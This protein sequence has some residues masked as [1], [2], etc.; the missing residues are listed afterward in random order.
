MEQILRVYKK[1]LYCAVIDFLAKVWCLAE[2]KNIKKNRDR[3]CEFVEKFGGWEDWNRVSLPYLKMYLERK[4]DAK[5]K[6]L[7]KFVERK[8]EESAMEWRWLGVKLVRNIDPSIEEISTLLSDTKEFEKLRKFR[9]VELLWKYRNSLI[10]ETQ[11]KGS[12]LEKSEEFE[13]YYH[14]K[15]K[16]IKKGN[17]ITSETTWELVYPLFFLERLAENSLKN[18]KEWVIKEKKNPYD[19]PLS[20]RWYWEK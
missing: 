14:T 16:Y 8:F 15:H 19:L 4:N 11:E 12:P 17:I 3:F 1:I 2:R 6:R 20:S 7:K 9:H 18:L 13:P 5:F 10:H